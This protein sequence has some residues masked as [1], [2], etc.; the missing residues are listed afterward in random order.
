MVGIAGSGKTTFAKSEYPSHVRVSL[1]DIKKSRDNVMRLVKEYESKNCND[2]DDDNNGVKTNDD[3][4]KKKKKKKNRL[5]EPPSMTRK[6]EHVLM[7]SALVEGKDV[8]V[9]DTNL[10][11]EIRRHHILHAKKFGY[12]I[13]VVSFQNT[14]RARKQN[15][16]RNGRQ[17]VPDGVLNKQLREY[18]PPLM[19]EGFDLVWALIR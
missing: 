7:E 14:T 4:I 8:V 18:E 15:A 16:E 12:H 3:G 5:P 9:D 11:K 19:E 17:R 1:D 10:T 13:N 2:D 6:A